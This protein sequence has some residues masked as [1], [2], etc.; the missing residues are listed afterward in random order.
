MKRHEVHRVGPGPPFKNPRFLMFSDAGNS[1]S[2]T[3]SLDSPQWHA[4]PPL[5]GRLF[6][7]P[8]R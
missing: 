2:P 1:R 4:K 3:P 7:V 8:L 5:L 6:V